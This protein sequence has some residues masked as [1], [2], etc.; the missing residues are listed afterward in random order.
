MTFEELNLNKPL[1]KALEDLEYR[2]KLVLKEREELK[3]WSD[4]ELKLAALA[5]KDDLKKGKRLDSLVVQAFAVVNEAARRVL[6]AGYR[7]AFH[8]DPIIAYAGAERDYLALIEELFEAIAPEQIAFI[9]M[10]GLRMTP[11]L[12]AAARRRERE[13]CSE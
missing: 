8:L 5:F 1:L 2:V 11:A 10:G 9:S 3:G 13:R 12:R 6:D 7:V 4:K